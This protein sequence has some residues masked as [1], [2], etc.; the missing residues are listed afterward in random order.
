MRNMAR[1]LALLM[2][3]C[4][5]SSG[6][7]EEPGH[8]TWSY[9]EPGDAL[10]IEERAALY[11]VGIAMRDG[12]RAR[13]YLVPDQAGA[14][15]S[16]TLPGPLPRT[17]LRSTLRVGKEGIFARSITPD[18]LLVSGP[19]Q[20]GMITLSFAISATDIDLFMAARDWELL[21]G[22]RRYLFPMTGSRAA[23]ETA[24]RRMADDHLPIAEGSN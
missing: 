20:R 8:G 10:F 3:L 21:L 9:L 24:Q 17:A 15:A 4:G 14:V 2:I 5:A 11:G 19:D 13:L 18:A 1:I 23:I 22:D 16:V 6:Q 12:L 7:A